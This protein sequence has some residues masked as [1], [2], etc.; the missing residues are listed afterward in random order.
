MKR[1]LYIYGGQ[2]GKEDM[3]DFISYDVDTQSLEYL[4]KDPNNGQGGGSNSE[5]D[6][7]SNKTDGKI[8]PPPVALRATIDCER[9]EIYVFSVSVII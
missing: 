5:N 7:S 8:A 1:K 4:N 2:R 9:D 6:N 3:H